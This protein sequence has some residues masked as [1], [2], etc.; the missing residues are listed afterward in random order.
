[1]KPPQERRRYHHLALPKPL[2]ARLGSE[3]VFILDISVNG[4]RVAH[5]GKQLQLDTNR[6]RFEWHGHELA[7]DCEVVRTSA[8]PVSFGKAKAYESGLF[9]LEP[10]AGSGTTIQELIG[11]QLMRVL[12]ERKANARGIPP[13]AA[14][15]VRTAS[16]EY[17][18]ITYRYVNG[19]WLTTPVPTA[20]QPYDGFTVSASEPKEQVEMLCQTYSTADFE[21]RKMIRKMAELSLSTPE[22]VATRK[23]QP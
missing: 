12:D 16:K 6:L 17:G 20:D 1:M 15:Y 11:E 23:F 19:E 3:K 18:Y 13:I 21:G 14:T 2:P 4:A 22:G 7:F 10:V 8:E 5:Q 9:F